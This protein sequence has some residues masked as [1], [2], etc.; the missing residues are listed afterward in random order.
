MPTSIWSSCSLRSASA[1]RV[2]CS[3]SSTA[4]TVRLPC[5]IR[6]VEVDR[7]AERESRVLALPCQSPRSQPSIQPVMWWVL[8]RLPPNPAGAGGGERVEAPAA[9]AGAAEPCGPNG[10]G[11][12]AAVAARTSQVLTET[13]SR[14]AAASMSA[15][16]ASD[17]RSEMRALGSPSSRRGASPSA[18]AAVGGGAHLQ[19]DLV[20][21]QPGGDGRGAGVVEQRG[22]GLVGGLRHRAD[23]R[24]PHRRGGG[25]G[26]RAGDLAG[27]LVAQRGGRDE[28]VVDGAQMMVELHDA[29]MTSRCRHRN[30][31]VALGAAGRADG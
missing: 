6:T 4:S 21:V 30:P 13:P 24:Q 29:T 18:S 12:S 28:L 25:G 1:R 20:A 14:S 23:Q 11:S 10:L 2:A 27:A 5:P 16:S 3:R 19:R 9:G 7:S 17:S 15:L 8:R 31:G 26:Q 22:G